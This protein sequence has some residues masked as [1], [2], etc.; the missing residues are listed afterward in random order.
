M[1][2]GLCSNIIKKHLNEVDA[3]ILT[4]WSILLVGIPSLVLL[5]FTA[6]ASKVTGSSDVLPSLGLVAIL[7]VVGTALAVLAHYKLIQ[8]STPLF[9]AA[10]A[11]LIPVIALFWGT[12]D[13]DPVTLNT[14]IGVVLILV[15]VKLI[16]MD[17]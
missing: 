8:M 7:G 11:Y 16:E 15:S 3:V 12:L 4:A 10:V 2:Y 1:C 9:G 6:V 14:L 5:P 17:D 13:G